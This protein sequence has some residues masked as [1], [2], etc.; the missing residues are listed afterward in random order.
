[1]KIL[2]VRR[3]FTT[4]S[5]SASEWSEPLAVTPTNS[6]PQP[7]TP[8][9]QAGGN[10]F[11]SATQTP[12]SPAVPHKAPTVFFNS[13]VL[14]GTVGILAGWLALEKISLTIWKRFKSKPEENDD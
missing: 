5:S 13:V 2:R 11:S 6:D 14:M 4:N 3:G 12:S 7:V 9:N 8:T 10:V 1:M